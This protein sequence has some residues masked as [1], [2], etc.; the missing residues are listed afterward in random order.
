MTGYFDD[1][2]RA[3]RDVPRTLSEDAFIAA[4]AAIEEP[5]VRDVTLNT[6]DREFP[7]D[8]REKILGIIATQAVYSHAGLPPTEDARWTVITMHYSSLIEALHSAF[9]ALA[10]RRLA[11]RWGRWYDSPRANLVARKDH[12]EPEEQP[13]R[14]CEGCGAVEGQPCSRGGHERNMVL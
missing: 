11:T 3:V 6:G 13:V 1:A 14:H 9:H 2:S 4:V 12:D 10:R 8:L 7:D 5:I